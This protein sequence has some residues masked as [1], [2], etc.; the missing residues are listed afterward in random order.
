[1][2]NRYL[3][4]IALLLV[5]CGAITG[6]I[7]RALI[8]RAHASPHVAP[9]SQSSKVTPVKPFERINQK[10][11]AA[12]HSDQKADEELAF[13]VVSTL[14]PS[15]VPSFTKEALMER[16]ARAE[17]NHRAGRSRGIPEDNVVKM[18]NELAGKFSAPEY[19]KTTPLEVRVARTGLMADMPNLIAD[20]PIALKEKGKKTIGLM[21]PVEAF[22]VSMFVLRQKLVN[23]AW[24]V[25]PREFTDNLYRKKLERWHA[26]RERAGSNQPTG[27]ESKP[28]VKLVARS[29]PKKDEMVRVIADG[30]AR[31]DSHELMGLADAALNTLGVER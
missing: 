11:K 16:L 7:W 17:T 24:Q 18:I 27:G 9:S 15:Q 14:T 21:S 30:A 25:S 31:M 10:A 5:C 28:Q 29:N 12:K 6:L 13:E 19:A 20:K 8:F 4:L 1:M 2:N 22:A 23:E 26:L 3:K